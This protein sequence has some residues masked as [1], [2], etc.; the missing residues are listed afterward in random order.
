MDEL[1]ARSLP[2]PQ[3]P[4]ARVRADVVREILGGAASAGGGGAG[5]ATPKLELRR[6]LQTAAAGLFVDD[7][8]TEHDKEVARE[9]VNLVSKVRLCQQKASALL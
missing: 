7:T 5:A 6:H 1:L 2:A 8:P 4:K 3:R 9:I